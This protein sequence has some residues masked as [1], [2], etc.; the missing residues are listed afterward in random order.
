[1]VEEKRTAGP[2]V[3]GRVHTEPGQRTELAMGQ[4][5]TKGKGAGCGR[6]TR[7]EPR[8]ERPRDRVA[9]MAEII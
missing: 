3:S 8:T 6:G 2:E 4:G 5:N 7:K 1:M 9:K